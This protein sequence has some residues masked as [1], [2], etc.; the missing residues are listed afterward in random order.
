M[1]KHS[2]AMRSLNSLEQ[3]T[4]SGHHWQPAACPAWWTSLVGAAQRLRWHQIPVCQR[5]AL[6]LSLSCS[7]HMTEAITLVPSVL[8]PASSIKTC[9]ILLAESGCICTVL[10]LAEASKSYSNTNNKEQ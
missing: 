1:C 2:F 3:V 7:A 6:G 4:S 5:V 8:V 9:N 10:I